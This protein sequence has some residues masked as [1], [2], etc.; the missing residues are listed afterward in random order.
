MEKVETGEARGGG[1]FRGVV[2][3][4]LPDCLSPFDFSAI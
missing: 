3:H 1:E 2:L 4:R